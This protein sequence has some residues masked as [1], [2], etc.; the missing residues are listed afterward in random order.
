MNPACELGE[1][2]ACEDERRKYK[3]AGRIIIDSQW[4]Y[5]NLLGDSA[6]VVP[7]PLSVHGDRSNLSLANPS[8]AINRHVQVP[9]PVYETRR[10]K[11]CA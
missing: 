3:L 10:M 2:P 9:L 8:L 5:G 7:L 11:D 4:I 6:D 1:F